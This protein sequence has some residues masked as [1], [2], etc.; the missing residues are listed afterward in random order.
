MSGR[1]GQLLP[2][3]ELLFCLAVYRAS[4]QSLPLY[5]CHSGK[6]TQL[7]TRFT[8]NTRKRPYQ[9]LT[10]GYH[11]SMM[12]VGAE[13]RKELGALFVWLRG[14]KGGGLPYTAKKCPRSRKAVQST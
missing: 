2:S 5:A 11:I 1:A 3:G 7:L 12:Q 4:R 14:P 10:D 8:R 6:Q 9:L 13:F